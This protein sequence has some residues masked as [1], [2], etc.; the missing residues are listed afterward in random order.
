VLD[1]L[2]GKKVGFLNR[3]SAEFGAINFDGEIEPAAVDGLC[4]GEFMT[5]VAGVVSASPPATSSTSVAL[6]TCQRDPG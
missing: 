3:R 6:R 2:V 1:S 5:P 4:A